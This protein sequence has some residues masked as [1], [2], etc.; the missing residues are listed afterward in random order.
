MMNALRIAIITNIL[1]KYREGF[2]DALFRRTDVIV[3]VYCQERIPGADFETIH[4]KYGYKVTLMKYL[5]A[6][7]EKIAVQFIPWIKILSESDVVFVGGNPRVV[8]DVLLGTLLTFMRK[9]VVL[10]TMA[11]SFRNN[12]LAERIRLRWSRI[13]RHILVYTDEEADYLKRRGF[14]KNYVLGINNGLDQNAIEQAASSWPVSELN[15]WRYGEGIDGQI[16]ILSC[17]RLERKNRLDLVAEALPILVSLIPNLTWCIIGSGPELPELK[18]LVDSLSMND[19]VRFVGGLYEERELAPWFMSSKLLVHPAAVGLSLLHA[20]GY[21]LPVIVNDNP[22]SHGPEY[23]AFG[24]GS[25]GLAFRENDV[26]HLADT[27]IKLLDDHQARTMM[28]EKAYALARNKYN[29]NIMVERLIK[30]ATDAHYERRLG[31]SLVD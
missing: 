25:T 2:Y 13:F 6:R 15:E 19:H 11:R 9:K 12:R 10:W 26:K 14:K 30:I 29:T 28:G 23:A 31:D 21:G 17:A 3:R 4:G 1:P 27:I 7:R 22:R 16:L 20:F 18:A 24:S 8:S 5:S